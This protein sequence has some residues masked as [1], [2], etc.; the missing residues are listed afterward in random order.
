MGEAMIRD[1]FGQHVLESDPCADDRGD[2]R[3]RM[4]LD[5]GAGIAPLVRRRGHSQMR[6]LALA[7]PPFLIP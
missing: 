6:L 2:S 1:V 5:H 3:F 7:R 4:V